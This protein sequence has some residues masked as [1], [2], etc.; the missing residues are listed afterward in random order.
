M[1]LYSAACDRPTLLLAYWSVCHELNRV[2]PVQYSY[3]VLYP[4][5]KS[6][7]QWTAHTQWRHTVASRY[8]QY[9]GSPEIEAPRT[10]RGRHRV[11]WEMGQGYFPSQSKRRY[12][13]FYSSQLAVFPSG[14][15]FGALAEDEFNVGLFLSSEH[16][17]WKHSVASEQKVW[18]FPFPSDMIISERIAISIQDML[19]YWGTEA[20]TLPRELT[21]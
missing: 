15:H 3:V 18:L 7:R 17:W 1:P 8:R 6:T 11:V 4:P 14:D 12:S 5:L 10:K 19:M 13:P 2:S 9:W 20:L 16:F 21:T